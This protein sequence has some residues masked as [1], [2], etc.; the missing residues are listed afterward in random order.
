MPISPP[1]AIQALQEWQSAVQ[2]HRLRRLRLG[3]RVLRLSACLLLG[4]REAAVWRAA[5]AAAGAIMLVF[6][7]WARRASADAARGFRPLHVYDQQHQYHQHRQCHQ[8]HQHREHRD[9]QDA[10]GCGGAGCGDSGSWCPAMLRTPNPRTALAQRGTAAPSPPHGE[11]ALGPQWWPPGVFAAD[12]RGWA[13]R[14]AAAREVV[15]K[16]AAARKDSTRE[17]VARHAARE[18]GVA[19]EEAVAREAAEAA[20]AR[21]AQ[22]READVARMG[23]GAT[24]RARVLRAAL[25]RWRQR[26]WL[27]WRLALLGASAARAQRVRAVRC[28]QQHARQAW[29]RALLGADALSRRRRRWL[30]RA[31]QRWVRGEARAAVFGSQLAWGSMLNA[32]SWARRSSPPHASWGWHGWLWVA[33]RTLEQSLCRSEPEERPRHE[34]HSLGQCCRSAEAFRH[35]AGAALFSRSRLLLTVLAQWSR[36]AR[37]RRHEHAAADTRRAICAAQGLSRWRQAGARRRAAIGLA[38]RGAR[39]RR[40]RGLVRAVQVWREGWRKEVMRRTLLPAATLGEIR[41]EIRSLAT[42]WGQARRGRA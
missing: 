41:A 17:A 30:Q 5:R 23:A 31:W 8:H 13:A 4:R 16:E 37:R 10:A 3:L 2:H 7:R 35:Q 36:A 26:C 22:L 24:G 6:H 20:A 32:P 38:G 11:S 42:Q 19:R 29:R 39:T 34:H 33:P 1:L 14:E 12:E 28:W 27:A 15:A 21:E 40:H 25:R 9:C 18:A